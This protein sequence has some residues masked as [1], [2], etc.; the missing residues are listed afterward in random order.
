MADEEDLPDRL[1]PNR[2]DGDEVSRRRLICGTAAAGATVGSAST[3]GCTNLLDE[4]DADE[5]TPE[6]DEEEAPDGA[7]DDDEGSPD[8]A[9]DGDEATPEADD[10]DGQTPEAN[11][12][13]AA[14]RQG[15]VFVFNWGGSAESPSSRSDRRERAGRGGARSYS[16]AHTPKTQDLGRH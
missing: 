9:D 10:A 14:T 7:A 3:A 1:V 11:D 15:Y 8:D 13:E 5:T 2:V 16:W 6:D 4:E 12:D